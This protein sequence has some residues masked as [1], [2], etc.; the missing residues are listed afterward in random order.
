MVANGT[1]VSSQLSR[2]MPNDLGALAYCYGANNTC[3]CGYFSAFEGEFCTESSGA[4]LLGVCFGVVSTVL[5]LLVLAK[6]VGTLREVSLSSNTAPFAQSE[7]QSLRTLGAGLVAELG[8]VAW[9]AGQLGMF[10]RAW[11][12]VSYDYAKDFIIAPMGGFYVF[13]ALSIAAV[14][15]DVVQSSKRNVAATGLN[16]IKRYL[17]IL[18]VV[19]AIA[20]AASASSLPLFLHTARS[21]SLSRSH[22]LPRLALTLYTMAR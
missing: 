20:R 1:E 9:C 14:W 4:T 12:E 18:V 15:I 17:Y 21:L 10:G 7:R 13:S 8:L 11:G 6:Q 2:C 3:V 16:R 5:S 19:F 22:R